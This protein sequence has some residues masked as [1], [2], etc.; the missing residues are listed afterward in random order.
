MTFLAR[1]ARFLFWLLV[2]SW[3]VWLLRR[4]VNWIVRNAAST[5]QQHPE[6]S[7]VAQVFGEAR[8]LVRDPVCGMHVDQTLAIPLREGSELVHFCSAACRDAYTSDTKK[9][10]AS[11]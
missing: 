5:P 4:I 6:A 10:A 3:S 1:I 7:S 2:V 9:F 11:G 8:R